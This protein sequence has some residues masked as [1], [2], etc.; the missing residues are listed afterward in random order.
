MMIGMKNNVCNNKFGN[1]TVFGLEMSTFDLFTWSKRIKVGGT[2]IRF[3]VRKEIKR[4]VGVKEKKITF[5]G[6]VEDI[7]EIREI[8]LY[9]TSK[10]FDLGTVFFSPSETTR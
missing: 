5:I 4:V 2:N 8:E 7:I 6:K 10:T 3:G 9:G 1:S